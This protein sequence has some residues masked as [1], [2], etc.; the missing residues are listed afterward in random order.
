MLRCF[1]LNYHRLF[2]QRDLHF[3]RI[4]ISIWLMGNLL[5]AFRRSISVW[6]STLE[7]LH[8]NLQNITCWYC[9]PKDYM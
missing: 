2:P 7:R 6:A 8:V 4:R 9:D 3:A 1:E 5:Q